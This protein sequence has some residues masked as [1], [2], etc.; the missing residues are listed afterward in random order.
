MSARFFLSLRFIQVIAFLGAI[1]SAP[2]T[3]AQEYSQVAKDG[4]GAVATVHPLATQAAIDALNNGGNAVDAAVAAAFTL[5]VVDGHNSGIGGGCF[6]LVRWANGK[7]EA[8]DGREM[9][10]GAATSDMYIRDGKVDSGLSKTG[11]L[12][13]G[14]PGSVAALEYLNKQ[15]GKL[16]LNDL[17][18]PAANLAESGFPIDRVYASRLARAAPSIAKFSSSAKILLDEN[19][20]PWKAGHQLIQKDLS[21]TYKGIASKGAKY[22]YEGEFAKSVGAWMPRNGGI[23][24]AKDFSGYE[25]KVREPV[26]TTYRDYTVYGFPPPSSGGVHVGQI[27][28]M[29]EQFDVAS[30]SVADRYQLLAEAMKIAFADRAHW[31]GDPDYVDVPR[32]LIDKDYAKKLAKGIDLKKSSL[33]KNHGTPPKASTDIFGKH[34]THIA[35]ADK[36]GNWVAITTTV[37]TGFGSKVIVPGTGVILNNQMDD[38]SAK[39]GSPNAYR[40]VGAEA[41][42]IQPGKRPLSSMS[43]TIVLQDDVPIL[44]T[45]AAGGPTIITQ[46]LQTLVNHLDVGMP[47]SKALAAPRIH[48]QW[49]PDRLF[50]ENALDESVKGSLKKKGHDLLN[51]PYMGSS[52]AISLSD[53]DFVS[54]SEPRLLLRNAK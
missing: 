43:P 27:L 31:L 44:T 17:V 53:G 30:L 12:A 42:K 1:C 39:P 34:T 32:G 29:L 52:Q 25:L 22:F 45:G 46:V 26:K 38:F 49:T 14:I 24:T 3:I 48:H 6:A 21:K 51:R 16:S 35:A 41:N 50:A 11:S 23:I 10:P 36:E 4:K 19:G 20:K 47:L 13:I 7:V 37:N 40:L 8:V 15:G 54:V 2:L 33:V 5:G 28:N 18:T 9:A